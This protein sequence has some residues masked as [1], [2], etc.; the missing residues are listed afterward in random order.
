MGSIDEQLEEYYDNLKKYP[1]LIGG[2]NNYNNIAR[3]REVVFSPSNAAESLVAN[4]I[5]TFFLDFID[6]HKKI[7]EIEIPKCEDIKLMDYYVDLISALKSGNTSE[8][9][10][11]KVEISNITPEEKGEL[12]FDTLLVLFK[13]PYELLEYLQGKSK[14]EDFGEFFSYYRIAKG[15]IDGL[16]SFGDDIDSLLAKPEKID[17][18]SRT[19]GSFHSKY[20]RTIS[21]KRSN[22]KGISD[23]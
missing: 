17:I 23:K 21:K 3:A 20:E 9:N 2:T 13:G 16:I 4:K 14:I 19:I 15:I 11:V 5:T 10:R 6:I 18:L 1:E 8:I 7:T 22:Q 12:L